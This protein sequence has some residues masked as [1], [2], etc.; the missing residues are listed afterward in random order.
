MAIT[1]KANSLFVLGVPPESS[2]VHTFL[3]TLRK[4]SLVIVDAMAASLSAAG[5][6]QSVTVGCEDFEAKI[7]VVV[8]ELEILN[9][10]LMQL[11]NVGFFG[12]KPTNVD[13]VVPCLLSPEKLLPFSRQ[14]FV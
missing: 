9:G 2:I 3:S 4:D 1:Q 11:I 7:G 12:R 6:L 10:F 5:A 8:G 13:G 14:F